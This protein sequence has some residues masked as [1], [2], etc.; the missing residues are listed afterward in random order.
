MVVFWLP[1]GTH[2]LPRQKQAKIAAV[3]DG[4]TSIVLRPARSVMIH[5]ARVVLANTRKTGSPL[6]GLTVAEADQACQAIAKAEN[7]KAVES[8]QQSRT[9]LHPFVD[10]FL[11]RLLNVKE[12]EPKVEVE[13]VQGHLL[14]IRSKEELA[15]LIKALGKLKQGV[16]WTGAK[17][18]RRPSSRLTQWLNL[19]QVDL[20]WT[21][22]S[23]G[24]M[25]VLGLSTEDISRL[26]PNREYCLALDLWLGRWQ[27]RNCNDQL[28]YACNLRPISKTADD[29]HPEKEGHEW[30]DH[31]EDL[32][33]HSTEVTHS[34]SHEK[35][36]TDS[37]TPTAFTTLP[38]TSTIIQTTSVE[39]NN[40][41]TTPTAST[42][43]SSS[44]HSS[45]SPLTEHT[46]TESSESPSTASPDTTLEGTSATTIP[47]SP[48]GEAT[49]LQESALTLTT[50]TAHHIASE[51]TS[52]STASKET[53]PTRPQLQP[54]RAFDEMTSTHA[55]TTLTNNL[56]SSEVS[57][58]TPLSTTSAFSPT[59]TSVTSRP[60]TNTP[61]MTTGSEA[62]PAGTAMHSSTASH[63]ETSHI[64]TAVSS[65]A[66]VSTQHS[67]SP[68]LSV[69]GAASNIATTTGTILKHDK[70]TEA[71]TTSTTLAVVGSAKNPGST[72]S[73]GTTPAKGTT[74]PKHQ[75]STHSPPVKADGKMTTPGM[76]QS[77]TTAASTSIAAGAVGIATGERA[78]MS[79][80]STSHLTTP[81]PPALPTAAEMSAKASTQS[82]TVTTP[83]VAEVAGVVTRE[84]LSTHSTL[85]PTP[86]VT[87][88]AELTPATIPSTTSAFTR[89]AGE[90]T[91]S[92]MMR[93]DSSEP[94]GSTLPATPHSTNP[95]LT[96]A[97]GNVAE[98]IKQ[99]TS[100]S[101]P[102]VKGAV[103][104]LPTD[105]STS[106]ETASPDAQ[107]MTVGREIR[108]ASTTP[109][110]SA[111]D[112]SLSTEVSTSGSKV[113]EPSQIATSTQTESA[114][115]TAAHHHPTNTDKQ[116]PTPTSLPSHGSSPA[117]IGLTT[118]VS[119]APS[120]QTTVSQQ[121][122][123]AAAPAAGVWEGGHTTKEGQHGTLTS[124]PMPVKSTP[125]EGSSVGTSRLTTATPTIRGAA[126]ERVEGPQI[127]SASIPP[128]TSVSTSTTK[129]P[130]AQTTST[131]RG[132]DTSPRETTAHPV[133][134]PVVSRMATESKALPKNK[135]IASVAGTFEAGAPSTGSL[136]NSATVATTTKPSHTSPA[137]TRRP[138]LD[139]D[140][141][142]DDNDDYDDDDVNEPDDDDYRPTTSLL[143]ASV[144]D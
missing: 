133:Q 3:S 40:A 42:E 120:A 134:T 68:T 98:T 108:S 49:D 60:V 93:G 144:F 105:I 35:A 86:S 81:L 82:P 135:V 107:E 117:E 87:H 54:V 102:S 63:T 84:T 129:Q 141:D 126:G 123:Q 76:S 38:T 32:H 53:T 30:T 57:L 73:S 15:S 19:P 10:A 41:Q 121:T 11:D 128:G 132:V 51:S 110:T 91:W 14:S 34:Q 56:P 119:P 48:P 8:Y 95:K 106:T 116:L 111:T 22:G 79:T 124:T 140:D 136:S 138:R 127:S 83:A 6:W 29:Y 25:E 18:I 99:S 46:S 130:E 39:T 50:I 104:T 36:R 26:E 72:S 52:S 113:T 45:T 97:A 65:V 1:L 59:V 62:T 7:E 115:T 17:L 96:E 16:Y 71:T 142:G 131:L 67:N 28:A 44:T 75:S 114:A 24:S 27:A 55:P 58:S 122:T 12:S 89:T 77:T 47:S 85:T 100:A 101:T 64:S 92:A 2:S 78:T 103:G 70:S 139:D 4:L 137:T 109:T 33:S 118:T 31:D 13:E 61:F 9:L 90:I 66:T 5:Q 37:T 125:H 74:A 69:T 43:G 88:Q 143:W 21:D 23:S 20:T 112:H 80:S 94:S